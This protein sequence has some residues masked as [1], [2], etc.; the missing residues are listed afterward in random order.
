MQ[1]THDIDQATEYA[2]ATLERMAREKLPP[3]PDHFELWYAYYARLIPELTR[4]VDVLV[5][6]KQPLTE[7]RCRELFQRF[8][9][10]ERSE[11]AIRRAGDRIGET[12]KNVT[13]AVAEVKSATSE[14][15]GKL[16]GVNQKISETKNPEELKNLL[17]S[18]MEDTKAMMEKNQKLEAELD[19][20]SQVMQEMQKDLEAVRREALTDGLTGLA[21]R[22]ALDV[23]LE[24]VMESANAGGMPFTMMIIDIDH[25]KNFNDN[26]GHQVG[27][28]VLRL[29]AKTLV[30]GVKGR[31]TAARYGGEEFVII[32]PETSME[33]GMIVAN[34]LRKAIAGK[35]VINRNTGER[36]TRITIS[37]G[38]AEYSLGESLSSLIER[39]DAALYTAKHNGRNQVAAA[40]AAAKQKKEVS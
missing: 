32:L 12:I 25:F 31:D 30:E 2:K 38:V 29:V 40:P 24:K 33:S 26:Y 6:S 36:M 23:A 34:A 15:S 8:L 1:Y 17:S 7:E 35:E 18:M 21:N 19:Q 27:D 39:A 16:G 37:A 3:S 4:A 10:E 28:Q 9:S 5:Q 22:K 14:Y 13:G 11:E 20:S